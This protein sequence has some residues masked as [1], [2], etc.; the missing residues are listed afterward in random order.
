MAGRPRKPTHLKVVA[1]TAQP[2]RTNANEPTPERERPSPPSHLSDRGKAA[3]AEAVLIADRMGVLTEA[4][5]LALEDLAETLADLRAARASLERPLTLM[6]QDGDGSPK[7]QVF[8]KAGE[9]YYWTF[10]KSGPMRR[11]RPELADI[12]DASRRLTACLAKFG[13]SP[14]DRSRVSAK[15]TKRKNEFAE[16]G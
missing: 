13:M 10:G 14:A 7:E 12:A 16:L 9:R 15:G 4:D 2:C 11:T 3:W 6:G 1:G 8:A 5:P